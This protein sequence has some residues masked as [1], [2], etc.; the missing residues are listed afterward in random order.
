VVDELQAETQGPCI[1][2]ILEHEIF[3]TGSLS[4]E[5]RW[6]QLP[7]RAREEPRV[8]SVLALRLFARQRTMGALN[9]YSSQLDAF[10][11]QDVAVGS[12]FAAH[13]AVGAP[14]D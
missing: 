3:V 6:P 10:S 2:A 4:G 11:D 9:L 12:V 14:A 13:A 1:D 5:S 7:P 8:E